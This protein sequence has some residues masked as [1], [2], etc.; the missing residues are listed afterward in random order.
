MTMTDP[1]DREVG[2]EEM[3]DPVSGESIDQRQLAEQLLAQAKEQGVD[4]VCPDGLLNRLTKNVLETA[5]EAEMD[6]HLGYER[7]DP[8][9]RN[10]GNSRNGTRSKT[11]LTEIGPVEIDVPRDT[12]ASFDPKIVR[13]RQRR[14]DGID[15]IVLSLTARG[16]TT[17]EVAAHFDEVYGAKVSKE[18]ISK[19]TDKV[20]DQM[21]E[22]SS[23][24]LDSIYP[25][26]F[27]DALVI[28]VR[29]GQVV[30]KPFYVVVGVTTSGERDILGIWAG[31]DGGEGA[32]FWL[33]VFSELKNRGVTDV[34]IAVCDGLKGLPEAITTTWEHTIVQQCVI[35]LIRNSFR[36]AGRQHRDAIVRGLKPIYTA[37]SEQAATDRFDEF[38]KQWQDKYPAIVA[39]WRN[40]WAEFV[41]FLEYDVEIRKVI[42]TTNAIESIN[43]RYRRAIKARGH[44]PSDAAALKCLESA[45]KRVRDH[46]PRTP[47]P[48]HQ[49]EPRS[50]PPFI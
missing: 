27:V 25:V 18:T 32:R 23:R 38:A 36:Y 5:L 14:L 48:D 6:D 8:M 24:P 3:L 21:A 20:V 13:K 28:K 31:D 19:I 9:G 26:I 42:C 22:W 34:L 37:P 15:E 44:F 49:R 2:S 41:P 47:R 12:D 7:H 17:G 29:G 45:V 30:N 50:D 16:L 10:S 11:V 43:A 46:L 4:L 39:L 1:S 35:H 33:Q 40:A